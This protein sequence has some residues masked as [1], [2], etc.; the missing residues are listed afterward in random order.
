VKAAGKVSTRKEHSFMP[1]PASD[2]LKFL[3]ARRAF[4]SR[5]AQGASAIAISPALKTMSWAKTH[6]NAS[7][8]K[9]GYAYDSRFPTFYQS[10]ETPDRVQWIHERISHAGF[11]ENLNSITA[12]SDPLPWI[13]KIHTP[14]HIQNIQGISASSSD[15]VPVGQIAELA[16]GYA[17]GAVSDVCEGKIRNAF[18]C[19]RPPG[20]HA[21]NSGSN[22]YCYYANAAI[23]VRFAQEVYSLRRILL[24]DWDL[25]HGNGSQNLLCGDSGVLFFDTFQTICCGSATACGDFVAEPPD[26]ALSEEDGITKLRINVQMPSDAGNEV[27]QTLFDNRLR[28]AAQR[29]RP[30]LVLISCGFDLKKNDTHGTLQVTARGISGL[31]K[32]MMDIADTYAGGKLVALLEGGYADNETNN[33]YHGLAECAE[34]LVATLASGELQKESP[35]YKASAIKNNLSPGGKRASILY[36]NVLV[37]PVNAYSMIICNS[38]GKTIKAIRMQLSGGNRYD[39]NT[40]RLS[41]GLYILH[42]LDNSGNAL[43]LWTYLQR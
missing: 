20:H 27:F 1:P 12:L 11:Y 41:R 13:S 32:T 36:G 37:A 19:I 30:E 35:Y 21:I 15:Y 33:T 5:C 10:P 3:S 39:L 22:G 2:T 43:G 17:L 42:I 28:M 14:E 38:S 26:A 31:T 16:V 25:H 40:L 34:S 23:A 24:V 9:T 7:S 29:F 6:G 18:C 4:L 8:W